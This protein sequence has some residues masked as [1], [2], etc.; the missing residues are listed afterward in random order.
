MLFN[1]MNKNQVEKK[2]GG[3]AQNVE[4]NNFPPI[5]PSNEYLLPIEKKEDIL[6]SERRYIEIVRKN[7]NITVSPYINEMIER[8][9]KYRLEEGKLKKLS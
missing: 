3:E 8:N 4:N 5:F 7:K 1:Y 9:G 6:I 2:F